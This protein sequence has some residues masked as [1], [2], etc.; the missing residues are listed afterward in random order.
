MEKRSSKVRKD[1]HAQGP[2][3]KKRV[4]HVIDLKTISGLRVVFEEASYGEGHFYQVGQSGRTITITYNREHPFWRELVEHAAERLCLISR[5][6]ERLFGQ[7]GYFLG[8]LE[9]P[10]K[11]GSQLA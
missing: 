4:P 10:V 6:W 5:V 9:S 7:M 8:S 3:A 1:T 2:S 11:T